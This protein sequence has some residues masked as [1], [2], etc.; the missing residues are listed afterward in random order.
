[1]NKNSKIF[2]AGHKGL[3]GSALVR[4]LKSLGYTNL[5]TFDKMVLD[6]RNQAEVRRFFSEWSPEYVFL[7]AAKVG[8]IDYNR[9]QP[10]DFIYDNLQIQ[11]NI[12]DNSMRYGVKKLLFLGS[13]CIYPKIVPQPIKEE[14]LLSD[15]LEPTNEGYA[16]AKIAGLK[17]CQMYSKQYG[18][19]TISLMPANLYGPNDNFM[20]KQCHVIPGMI[21][22]FSYAK[23]NRQD[24]VTLFGDGSPKREFL[25]VD[26][27]ADACV[28]L[29]HN[30]ND[31]SH[32]NVGSDDEVTI[33]DLANMLKTVTGF[34]GSIVWDTSM[35]N[36][37]PLRKLDTS[38]INSL[39]WSAKIKL[40]DGV[41][42]T[43]SWYIDNNG[44]PRGLL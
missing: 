25:H 21:T 38:K 6:L 12:I 17:M 36:G 33:K 18:L 26:D 28:F 23:K 44:G 24:V 31:S 43:Y 37:T 7:A 1:M 3:V 40:E 41:K 22:K 35:P 14:Y 32:I 19:N 29:M 27:L 8:G 11:N 20:P 39:G 4:K 13:A 16:I 30:Y 5:I 10:A 42:E 15:Y 9:R 34:E 2:I